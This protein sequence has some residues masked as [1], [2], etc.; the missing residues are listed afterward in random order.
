MRTEKGL[1]HVGRHGTPK[2]VGE[3]TYFAEGDVKVGNSERNGESG[4]KRVY[5]RGKYFAPD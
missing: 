5:A 4:K 1:A 2:D 3:K